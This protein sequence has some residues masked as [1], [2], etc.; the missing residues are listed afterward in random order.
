MH[1][2]PKEKRRGSS[3]GFQGPRQKI[4]YTNYNQKIK[5]EERNTTR[6][7]L[8]YNGV[9]RISRTWVHY[10]EEVDS[11]FTF[12]AFNLC[13]LTMN[14]LYFQNYRFKSNFFLGNFSDFPH[15]YISI[16]CTEIVRIK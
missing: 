5:S 9:S 13:I 10:Y 11:G 7:P 12:D 1:T 14:S 6:D 2:T 15:M 8:A 4:K 3:F 16:I